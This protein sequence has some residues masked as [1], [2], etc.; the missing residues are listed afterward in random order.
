MGGKFEFRWSLPRNV[1]IRVDDFG[2][3]IFFIFFV[4]SRMYKCMKIRCEF[5]SLVSNIGWMEG[6]SKHWKNVRGREV[7]VWVR[8][9]MDVSWECLHTL[10]GLSKRGSRIEERRSC[11]CWNIVRKIFI[12]PYLSHVF[13]KAIK[14]YL[15]IISLKVNRKYLV[16]IYE[17]II[18][19]YTEKWKFRNI[20]VAEHVVS[21]KGGWQ[22]I[23]V[24]RLKIVVPR[25]TGKDNG[26]KQFSSC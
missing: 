2:K 13:I 4:G 19:N 26:V 12:K 3:T 22:K 5:L 1:R 16:S 23:L 8:F 11:S 18:W 10:H 14:I 25:S 24:E 20:S 15:W 7:H 6:T 17:T 21:I 9:W